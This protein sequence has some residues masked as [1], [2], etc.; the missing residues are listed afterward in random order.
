[1]RVIRF[2]EQFGKSAALAAGFA[3]ARGRVII[4]LDGDLQDDPREIPRFLA[5]LDDGLDLVCGW[6]RPRGASSRSNERRRHTSGSAEVQYSRAHLDCKPSFGVST[7]G[8]HAD[9]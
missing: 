2:A 7:R 1:M 8:G 3:A 4:T 5:A 6:R 9:P